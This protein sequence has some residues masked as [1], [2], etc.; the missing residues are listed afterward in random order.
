MAMNRKTGVGL[1]IFVG[2]LLGI[3]IGWIIWGMNKNN[4]SALAGRDCTLSDGVTKG[5]TDKNGVCIA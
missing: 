4:G 1:G 3:G 5:K 2:I